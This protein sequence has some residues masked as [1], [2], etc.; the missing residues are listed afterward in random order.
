MIRKKR[1]RPKS[2]V[3]FHEIV[4]DLFPKPTRVSKSV[5]GLSPLDVEA[6]RRK[7]NG[8][9][10]AKLAVLER[11]GFCCVH[12]KSTEHLTIDHVEA[13][14]DPDKHS[15]PYVLNDCRTLCAK[16]HAKVNRVLQRRVA[17]EGSL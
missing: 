17:K 14:G 16:C 8:R 15:K 6:L 9:A 13:G 3:P 2:S 7:E 10:R 11:D 12:C 1:V 5:H 4:S